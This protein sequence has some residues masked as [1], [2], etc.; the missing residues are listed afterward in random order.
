MTMPNLPATEVTEPD[1]CN[2]SQFVPFDMIQSPEF[3]EEL[4][5]IVVVP[6]AETL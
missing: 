3:H 5:S 6:F 2:L 1:G 4:P